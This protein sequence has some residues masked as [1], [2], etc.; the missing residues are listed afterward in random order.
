MTDVAAASASIQAHRE[1]AIGWLIY[2]QP[3]RH[4]ALSLE[5][6][7]AVPGVIDRFVSDPKVRVVVLRG[8]GDKAFISGADISEFDKDRSSIQGRG[9]YDE[10]F[11]NAS[12]ALVECQKPVLAMIQGYCIGGGLATAL[13]ADLRIAA[14]DSRFGIPAARLGLAYGFAGVK[15]LVDVVGPAFTSEILFSARQFDAAEAL[16]MGLVN[17]V[18][19]KGELE[20]TVRELAARLAENAPL[21]ILAAKAAIQESLRDAEHRDLERCRRLLETCFQSADYEEG[22]RA[23]RDKRRPQFRGE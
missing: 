20:E 9:R 1:G 21:T 5:M 13:L 4:N 6:Q 12:R 23:F 7:Q 8:A 3:E 15:R 22:R 18:V 17:R 11:G 19:A 14:E 10:V 2:S 16:Q